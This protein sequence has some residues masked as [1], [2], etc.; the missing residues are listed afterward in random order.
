MCMLIVYDSDA[1]LQ[2]CRRTENFAILP[3]LHISLLSLMKSR[4][5]C[6]HTTLTQIQAET[7]LLHCNI[8]KLVVI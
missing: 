7:K 2:V 5:V 4:W 1:V 3:D 6:L 8:V